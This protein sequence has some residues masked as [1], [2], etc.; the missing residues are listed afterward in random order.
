MWNPFKSSHSKPLLS[1][2]REI[3]LAYDRVVDAQA[4]VQK[5]MEADSHDEGELQRVE[6]ALCDVKELLIQYLLR[7]RWPHLTDAEI[8]D[9]GGPP[10][11]DRR[12][13]IFVEL[14]KITD[15]EK[16]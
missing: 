8:K 10:A 13:E 15:R 14:G 7:Q 5:L 4:G 1:N 3:A 11:F 12:L 9:T 16:K 2:Q 6:G